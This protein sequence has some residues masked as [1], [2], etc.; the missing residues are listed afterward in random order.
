MV[1]LPKLK[2]TQTVAE[3]QELVP[4]RRVDPPAAKVEEAQELREA[5][6]RKAN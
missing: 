3:G 4:A 1:K 2:L 6:A 5:M